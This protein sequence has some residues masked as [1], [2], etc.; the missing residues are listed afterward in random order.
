MSSGVEGLLISCGQI[1]AIF[2]AVET[3]TFALKLIEISVAALV[4][5]M[6]SHGVQEMMIWAAW[7]KLINDGQVMMT[8]ETRV[9][10][11][12]D[13]W[14]MEICVVL[15]MAT[16]FEQERVTSSVQE[17]VASSSQER[18]TSFVLERVI[19]VGQGKIYV[20]PEA[21]IVVSPKGSHAEQEM[22]IY[23]AGQE[24]EIFDGVQGSVIYA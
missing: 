1:R 7:V 3:R 18:V 22:E 14:E 12:Y 5:G 23:D 16:S 2:V 10:L 15:E 4:Q 9:K 11:I 21:V 17:R 8:C 19:C 24:T 13:A 20:A 6:G